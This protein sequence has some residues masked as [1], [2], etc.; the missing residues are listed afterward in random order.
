[1]D[2]NATGRLPLINQWNDFLL[3]QSDPYANAKYEILLN[4]LGLVDGKKCLIVG[5]GSGEFAVMLAKRGAIVLAI[6]IDKAFTDL[7]QRTAERLGV[8]LETQVSRLEDLSSVSTFDIVVATDVIEHIED[9]VR[10]AA[11]LRELLSLDGKLIITVPAMQSLFG[12][13]DRVLGHFRRYSRPQLRALFSSYLDI[14][15]LRYFGFFFI[16]VTLMISKILNRPYPTAAVGEAEARPSLV[17]MIIKVLFWFEK[18]FSFPMG[19]SLLLIGTR[20]SNR[21]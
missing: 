21:I 13:H 10:A 12:Y 14:Q 8:K 6:D 2:A 18:R 3:R 17:G 19:T 4:W 16:P 11:K 15:R 5:S 9:D 20:S 1:M 7:T